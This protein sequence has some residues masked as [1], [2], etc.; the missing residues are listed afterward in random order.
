[1]RRDGIVKAVNDVRE[2]LLAAQ[3]GELLRMMRGGEPAGN[4]NRTPH[5]LCAY[6]EFMRH[7]RQF[8]DEEKGLMASLG[9]SP[10][11]DIGFWGGLFEGPHAVDRQILSGVE[12][13][14]YNV[15]FMMPKLVELLTRETD[16]GEFFVEDG[17]GRDR[18]IRGLRVL[19][20]GKDRSLTDPNSAVLLI[21]SMDRLYK[22]LSILHGDNSIS[23][24]IGS[25]DSGSTKSFDIFGAAAIID[26]IRYLLA[27]VWD[28]VK[29]CGEE[30]LRYQIELAM[31][32][33]G[34]AVRV[35]RAQARN[36]VSEK[37]AQ[38]I[39]R[40]VAKAIE[41]LFRSGAYTEDMDAQRETRASRILTPKGRTMEFKSEP[42]I[43]VK[44]E[45]M[46]APLCQPDRPY[47]SLIA[48]SLNGLKDEH[49]L[50]EMIER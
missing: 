50:A 3:I 39:T 18:Q 24:A 7:I 9:L 12:V 22:T 17:L 38:R 15:T 21:R 14:A 32:A 31:V 6:H 16:K 23:L 36:L 29:Y 25:I 42:E 41:M 10:L 34:F 1:M 8:G 43:E 49:E 35:K 13:A 2:A 11:L 19:L 48:G 5:I 44:L 40:H 27:N 45:S 4:E 47:G 46:R 28:K 30:N 20:A 26:E 33:V 37:E